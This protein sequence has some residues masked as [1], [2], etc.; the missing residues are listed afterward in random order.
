MVKK[1]FCLTALLAVLIACGY[2]SAWAQKSYTQ[3]PIYPTIQQYGHS[4][5]FKGS[6]NKAIRQCVSGGCLFYGGNFLDNPN[7]PPFLPNA[8]ANETNLLDSPYYP[9][10]YGAAVWVPF[11]VPT[12]VDGWN[13][14][15]MFS[16]N[17]SMFGDL[18]QYPLTPTSAANYS[19]NSGVVAGSGGTVIAS[20]IAAA[21][22]TPTGRS[23]FG[24]TEYT[25]AV[26]LNAQGMGFP[27][28]PGQYWMAVVPI[29]TNESDS[30]C[31]DRSFMSDTEELN[32]YPPN[33][34]GPI[35]PV[36][37]AF[38]DGFFGSYSF[39]PTYGPSGACGGYGCDAFSAGVQG[40]TF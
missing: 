9:W 30:N 32:L 12:T 19:V 5:N 27:L 11:I 24:L 20:G 36:D 22:S 8:L 2:V 4:S 31:F 14:G 16:N 18:D 35:E 21:T 28:L 29:C 3:K 37:A 7:F 1:I 40:T 17:M 25:I 34:C 39:Y 33:H 26:N 38:F 13:V 23:G 10:P 15:G 6:S